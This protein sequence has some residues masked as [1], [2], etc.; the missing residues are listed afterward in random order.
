M[1][2]IDNVNPKA[3]VL[4]RASVVSSVSGSGLLT[5]TRMSK[6]RRNKEPITYYELLELERQKNE[7]EAALKVK[8][9]RTF[10]LAPDGFIP[11]SVVRKFFELLDTGPAQ[12]ERKVWKLKWVQ[13]LK[14]FG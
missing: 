6:K 3:S 9:K 7:A 4:S 2:H 10:P 8:I 1:Y 14:Y 5:S 11:N 12:P 13:N